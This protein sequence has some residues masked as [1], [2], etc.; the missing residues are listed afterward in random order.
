MSPF[1]IL[2]FVF[3]FVEQIEQVFDPLFTLWRADNFLVRI[4][5]RLLLERTATFYCRKS[6]IVLRG[7]LLLILLL[8][9]LSLADR[10]CVN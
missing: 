8:H 10:I 3:V 4:N 6:M 7:V 1:L 5:G 9:L 2:V